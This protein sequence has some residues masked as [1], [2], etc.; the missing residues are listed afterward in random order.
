MADKDSRALVPLRQSTLPEATYAPARRRWW[1]GTSLKQL[2]RDADYARSQAALLDAQAVEQDSM[3]VLVERSIEL[4]KA[5]AT[6]C[7]LP[8]IIE[9]DIAMQRLA[10]RHAEVQALARVRAAERGLLGDA[11]PRAPHSGA[12]LSP[13]EVDELLAQLP[14][15]SSD[16]RQTITA[17]LTARLKEKAP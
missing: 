11:D 15:I 4:T 17:L 14:E 2:K 5:V 9:H 12:G 8:E 16:T 3:R 6:L 1:E 13:A 10:H 7:W